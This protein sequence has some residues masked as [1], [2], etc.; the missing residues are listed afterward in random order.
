[1]AA[2]KI[3]RFEDK[4]YLPYIILRIFFPTTSIFAFSYP[5][6]VLLIKDI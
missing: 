4:E 6:F 2:N 5:Y 3:Q 1:M